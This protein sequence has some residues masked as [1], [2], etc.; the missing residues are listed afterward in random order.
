MRYSLIVSCLICSLLMI[1]ACV[2][3]VAERPEEEEE[4]SVDSTKTYYV[5]FL[6][7]GA[8][9]SP[10]ETDEINQLQKEHL[11]NIGRLA[12]SGLLALAGPF[13][14]DSS[15]PDNPSQ[16]QSITHTEGAWSKL[17]QVT[18]E[19]TGDADDHV[20]FMIEDSFGQ[21]YGHTDVQRAV[22]FAREDIGVVAFVHDW[23]VP[24]GHRCY[25]NHCLFSFAAV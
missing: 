1:V 22:T 10:E 3:Q 16:V 11:A 2:D 24:A 25:G 4:E 9:W 21:V 18:V 15:P 12:D 8:T 19:W 13:I 14:T 5:G 6:T 17:D 20:A 23:Y 7:R